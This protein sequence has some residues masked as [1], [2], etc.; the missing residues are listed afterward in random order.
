M[1]HNTADEDG[2]AGVGAK[3]AAGRY[4]VPALQRGLQL[5]G[6]FKR[7]ERELT[8]AELS[9]RMDLPR[10]RDRKSTRLNSSHG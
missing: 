3:D 4:L 9:R 1:R 7:N 2:G 5:L 6:E 10:A 8:G